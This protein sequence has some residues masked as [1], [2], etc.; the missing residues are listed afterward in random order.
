M[1]E[2]RP[3]LSPGNPEAT[4]KRLLGDLKKLIAGAQTFEQE[5]AAAPGGTVPAQSFKRSQ[6]IESLSK[7]I[8]KSLKQN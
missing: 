5:L 7:K 4:R 3:E 2:V 8:R 1:V 6:E